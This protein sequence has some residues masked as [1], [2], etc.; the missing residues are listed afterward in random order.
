MEYSVGSNKTAILR[1]HFFFFLENNFICKD[2]L[3][4]EVSLSQFKTSLAPKLLTEYM[5]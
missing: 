2:A 3:E 4:K 1:K 5:E